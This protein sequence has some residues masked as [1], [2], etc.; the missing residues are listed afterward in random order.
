MIQLDQKNRITSIDFFRFFAVLAVIF[1]HA[2]P[3]KS[4]YDSYRAGNASFFIP[5]ISEIVIRQ[6]TVFAIPY[7]YIIAGYFFGTK[8]TDQNSLGS[9]L[10]RYLK[11]LFFI[12]LFWLFFYF[13]IPVQN[14]GYFMQYGYATYI[15]SKIDYVMHDP[16]TIIN[17]GAGVGILYFLSYLMISLCII[18][19]LYRLH[20]KKIIL[21]LAALFCFLDL[22]ASSYSATPVGVALNNFFKNN[23]FLA[24]CYLHT[25]QYAGSIFFV[26]IGW[27]LST[28]K[29]IINPNY[30]LGLTVSGLFLSYFTFFFL[31]DQ[32]IA[33]FVATVLYAGGLAMYAIAKPDLDRNSFIAKCGKL[34]LGVYATHV[35]SLNVLFVI[36]NLYPGNAYWEI[37]YPLSAYCL[38]LIIVILFSKNNLLRHVVI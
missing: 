8:I 10:A 25:A 23:K 18:A 34:S 31:L 30:S 32:P 19:L 1:I 38:S 16:L 21:L 14:F 33:A 27:W 17:N 7:F 3:F 12:W 4:A 26:A 6:A 2:H 15:R 36:Y 24:Q 37:I 11:R 35:L 9:V 22:T 29:K 28:R 20:L 5:G 13:F